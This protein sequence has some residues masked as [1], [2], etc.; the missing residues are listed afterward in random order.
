MKMQAALMVPC[1]ID[2]FYPHVG[3]ATRGRKR[4]GWVQRR[5]R[6]GNRCAK[7]TEVLAEQN[8]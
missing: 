4:T 7:S 8:I 3:I 2:M 6:A 1:Y 5:R